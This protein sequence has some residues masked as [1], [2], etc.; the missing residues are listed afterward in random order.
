[1]FTICD[2]V[3]SGESIPTVKTHNQKHFSRGGTLMTCSCVR[4]LDII[5]L[6][7]EFSKQHELQILCHRPAGVKVFY[8]SRGTISFD[9]PQFYHRLRLWIPAM[10]WGDRGINLDSI[11]QIKSDCVNKEG[12]NRDAESNQQGCETSYHYTTKQLQTTHELALSAVLTS[13]HQK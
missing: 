5:T 3:K 12:Q 10:L 2:K 6:L 9:E 8:M 4:G 7:C 11:C 1:M 13:L